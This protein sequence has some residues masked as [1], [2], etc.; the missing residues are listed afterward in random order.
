MATVKD[1]PSKSI[2][3]MGEKEGLDLILSIRQ[4]R[5]TPTRR[6][7]KRAAARKKK[8]PFESLTDKQEEILLERLLSRR[9]RND[10][11]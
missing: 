6:S 5:S 4:S 9:E 7:A 1:L 2:L 3:E 11:D 8:D 10:N